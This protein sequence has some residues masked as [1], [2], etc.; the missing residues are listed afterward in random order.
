MT[1]ITCLPCP[2]ILLFLH[3]TLKRGEY[4]Q[5]QINLSLNKPKAIITNPPSDPFSELPVP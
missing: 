4:K 5:L 1:R 3:H 2:L